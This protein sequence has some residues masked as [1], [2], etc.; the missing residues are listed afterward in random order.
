MPARYLVAP[1]RS[2]HEQRYAVKDAGEHREKLECRA[3]RPVQVIKEHRG[4]LS[5]GHH[6]EGAAQSLEERRAV[7]SGRDRP[8]LR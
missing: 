6:L 1:E 2:H 7:A 4:S 3:I 8:K 5:S